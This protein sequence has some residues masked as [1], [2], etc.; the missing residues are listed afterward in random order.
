[1][2]VY[3]YLFSSSF[4]QYWYLL[5][6]S[7][8]SLSDKEFEDDSPEY[9]SKRR[10]IS[11]THNQLSDSEENVNVLNR[12][13][14]SSEKQHEKRASVDNLSADGSKSNTSLQLN[15]FA[16]SSPSNIASDSEGEDE[17]AVMNVEERS[18]C[19]FFIDVLIADLLS[20]FRKIRDSQLCEHVHD[21]MWP[22]AARFAK[23]SN[24]DETTGNSKILIPG[25]LKAVYHWQ[26]LCIFVVMRFNSGDLGQYGALVGDEMGLGKV[27]PTDLLS[28]LPCWLCLRVDLWGYR[29]RRLPSSTA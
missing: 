18:V 15:K 21:N 12:H 10:R 11:K 23:I 5:A 19:I 3:Y 17:Q 9:S 8:R 13:S 7:K 27:K 6:V 22:R 2:F 24:P 25:M 20:S 16:E 4:P 26:W 14:P 1:M 28:D 29:R